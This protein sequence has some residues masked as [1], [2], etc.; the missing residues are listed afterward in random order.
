MPLF[1]NT[2]PNLALS[3]AIL[4]SIGSNI[5]APMPT[6][7]PL[8]APTIGLVDLNNLNVKTPPASLITSEDFFFFSVQLNE[9]SPVDKSAPAQYFFPSPVKIIALMSF[10][11]SAKFIASISSLIINSVKAFIFSGLER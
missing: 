1:A 6:A 2:N 5:V 3:L 7:S 9:S 11:S 8:I 10:S 4:T